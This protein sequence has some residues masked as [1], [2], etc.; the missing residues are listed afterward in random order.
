MTDTA[1]A[2]DFPAD[3][4]GFDALLQALANDRRR[5][6]VSV[7]E[8][9]ATNLVEVATLAH[10]LAAT[11]AVDAKEVVIELH[12]VHLPMLDHAGVLTYDPTR[13]VVEDVDSQTARALQSAV[14]GDF[15]R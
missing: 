5:E 15:D 8:A 7:L 9:Q 1:Y 4:A 2:T 3:R 10:Q 12:H 13:G 6:L 14:E 11:R